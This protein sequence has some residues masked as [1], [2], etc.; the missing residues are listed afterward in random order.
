MKK[1]TT[2]PRVRLAKNLKRLIEMQGLTVIQVADAAKVTTKQIY[3]LMKASFDPRI[4]SIEKVAGVF[5]L[6]VWQMIAVDMDNRPPEELAVL[7]LLERFVATD[8]AGRKTIMQVA[9][10]AAKTTP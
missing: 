6:Q 4:S 5:G 7:A 10:I 2:P 1:N 3:N 8:E 9:E